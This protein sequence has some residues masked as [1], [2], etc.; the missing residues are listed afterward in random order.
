MWP[1]N[2]PSRTSRMIGCD[3]YRLVLGTAGG[4][5]LFQSVYGIPSL[6]KGN[7]TLLVYSPRPNKVAL[8]GID[9]VNS[10]YCSCIVQIRMHTAN[11]S[12]PSIFAVA[13]PCQGYRSIT[14][15]IIAAQGQILKSRSSDCRGAGHTLKTNLLP[16]VL[17]SA[18]ELEPVRVTAKP[19]GCALYCK[20][21]FGFPCT[22]PVYNA[23]KSELSL[24]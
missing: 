13:S 4:W 6:L 8:D 10:R 22:L 7:P 16:A 11:P 21:Y 20:P 24:H 17:K 23:T 15:G 19:N 14:L 9:E 3:P 12:S 1:I 2:S 18:G 5:S